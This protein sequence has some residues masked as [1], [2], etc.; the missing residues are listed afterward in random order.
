MSQVAEYD[1]KDFENVASSAGVYGKFYYRPMQND[2]KT[3][4]AGRPIFDEVE[5][6]EIIAAGNGTNI[7]RRPARPQDKAR[8]RDAYIR[9]REGDNEQVVGTPLTE[10]TWISRSMVEELSYI[11]VRT[12][13]QLAELNDQACTRGPGLYELKRKAAA[14]IKKASDA[15]PFD[16]MHK[17]NEELKERLSNMEK[18]LADMPKTS[19]GKRSDSVE[20]E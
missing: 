20:T 12:L 19:K 16:A 8:F 18:M 2:A 5:F 9:F 13:E 15:A 4:E 1:P 3:E 7:V 11:K 17:E 10:V 14:F 6:V